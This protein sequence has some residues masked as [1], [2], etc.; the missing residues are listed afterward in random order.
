MTPP[1]LAGFIPATRHKR[2]SSASVRRG[3]QKVANETCYRC[4][5]LEVGRMTSAGDDMDP[6]TGKALRELVRVY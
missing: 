4:R 1:A 3:S 6:R 2:C 5:V